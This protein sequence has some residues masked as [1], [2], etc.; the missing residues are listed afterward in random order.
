L[1]FA[2][3]AAD[4]AW[5]YTRHGCCCCSGAHAAALSPA[6]QGQHRQCILPNFT[7]AIAY[8]WQANAA[9]LRKLG[10][11]MEAMGPCKGADERRRRRRRRRK[12]SGEHTRLKERQA[13]L[14][15]C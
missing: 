2:K 15:G 11:A 14:C 1:L 8:A 6:D 5:Q 13:A 9:E 3:N 4:E 7:K 12:I 10:L